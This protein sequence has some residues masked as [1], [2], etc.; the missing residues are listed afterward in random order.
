MNSKTHKVILI[1]DHTET[2]NQYRRV[3]NESRDFQVIRAYASGED[4]L[5]DLESIRPDVVLM[6]LSLPG[7]S[8]IECTKLIRQKFPEITI[9]VLTVHYQPEQVFKALETGAVG[10]IIKNADDQQIVRA[11]KEALQGGAPL[12]GSIARMVVTSFR[13]NQNT[14]LTDREVE[15]LEKLADGK[16]APHIAEELHIH[17]ETVRTHIRNIYDKLHVRSKA[18]AIQKARHTR[19]L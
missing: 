5:K 15:V 4:A 10:Y 16:T 3:V 2:C 1:E 6:D 12:S 9:I 14:S 11:I 7:M 18:E 13:R 17:K 8:G 19:L